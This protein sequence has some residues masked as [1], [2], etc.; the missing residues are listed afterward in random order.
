MKQLRFPA[1]W[2]ASCE[3]LHNQHIPA[4]AGTL[5]L[6]EES[7]LG[8]VIIKWHDQRLQVYFKHT[9]IIGFQ[10]HYSNQ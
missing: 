7:E 5:K 8:T 10:Q 6:C 1:D 3:S 2:Q 4:V 9:C